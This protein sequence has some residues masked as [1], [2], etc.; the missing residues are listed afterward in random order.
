MNKKGD[1]ENGKKRLERLE[2]GVID[3]VIDLRHE[4]RKENTGVL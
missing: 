3:I 2:V 4:Y 1:R